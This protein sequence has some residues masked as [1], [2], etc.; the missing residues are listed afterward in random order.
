[1]I[2]ETERLFIRKLEES[3][4]EVM[5]EIY[6]DKEAM[7][8]R[9]NKPFENINEAKEMI[10]HTENEFELGLK[11]R[12]AIIKKST[13]EL[14]GTILYFSE[15]PN[16]EICTIGYSLGKK[17]WKKGYALETLNSFINHLKSLN[18]KELQ[19]KVFKMNT[20]SITLLNKTGFELIEDNNEKLFTFKKHINKS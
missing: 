6:S 10:K 11:F 9:S 13:N 16:S 18:F 1:M 19:A 5:F 20:D 7:K 3:D 2:F 8:F 14:I 12:Y 15:Y 4:S 17:Y